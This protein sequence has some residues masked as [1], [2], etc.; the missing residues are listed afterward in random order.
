MNNTRPY[1]LTLASSTPNLQRFLSA[2]SNLNVEHI[3]I[4][5]E[6]YPGHIEK[7]KS[8]PENLDPERYVVFTD[9]DDVIFQ[10]PLPEFT[11]DLYLAPE[12]VSHRDTMWKEHIEKYPEFSALMD[13]EVY[14]CGQF[15]MKVKTM[16]EYIKFMMSFPD[17]GYRAL[18]FEQM[19]F[20]MFV[21]LRKDLSRVIDRTIFCP[22]FANVHHGV[23]KDGDVWVDQDAKVITCV[24]ANGDVTL[25]GQL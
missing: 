23:R 1:L 12:N 4:T 17:G 13:K 9:T 24:H 10:K 21:D 20:N 6:K 7:W 22:L 2:A 14:N 25:K 16:Y 15:A 3:S 19:Y 5:F 8:V 18:G 11:H